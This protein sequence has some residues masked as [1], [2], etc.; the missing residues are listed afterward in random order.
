MFSLREN[1]YHMYTHHRA[2]LFVYYLSK[3]PDIFG[4]VI[5]RMSLRPCSHI[6]PGSV[7]QVFHIIKLSSEI[8]IAFTLGIFGPGN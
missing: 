1:V 8:F 2:V 6:V 5:N 3:R 4:H 7:V